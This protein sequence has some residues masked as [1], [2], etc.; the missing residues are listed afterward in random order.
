MNHDVMKAPTR[1]E[2]LCDFLAE[3]SFTAQT[4]YVPLAECLDRVAAEDIPA[5]N[6]IPLMRISAMDGY[7]VKAENFAAG[8]PDVSKWVPGVDF[9]PADTGDDFPDEYDTVIPV[10]QLQYDEDGVLRLQ[11]DFVFKPGACVRPAGC[12]MQPGDLLVRKNTRITPELQANLAAGG[13]AVVPV[14]RKPVIAYIPT[15]S[16]LVPAGIAPQRGQNIETNSLMLSAYLR[17]WGAQVMSYPIVRDDPSALERTMDEALRFADI[18]LLNGGSSKGTEDFNS[19]M[20]ERR[21]SWF[22]HTVRTVPGRPV[23]LSI[24]DGKPVINLP[25]PI[26]AAWVVSSW[27]LYPMICR[28]LG[29]PEEKRRTVTAFLTADLKKGPPV[30]VYTKVRLEKRG[31]F[32]Y[33][34]PLGRGARNSETLR[35][36]IGVLIAPIGQF[37]WQKGEPVT[38]ELLCAEE[39]IPVTEQPPH[40]EL[41]EHCTQC[42]N[43][44]P[45]EALRCGRGK[46]YY[47][48]LKNGEEFRCDNDAV[49]ALV[50]CAQAA[51]HMGRM[52]TLHGGSADDILSALNADEQAQLLA[53]LQKQQVRWNE[54][55]A[56]RHLQKNRG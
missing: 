53:L 43:H 36:G 56:R 28:W 19:R 13:I 38:V 33:A 5:V 7:A 12:M 22:L 55:H 23:G 30:E 6:T 15:G 44:C 4:E 14:V 50:E 17:R 16:E 24:I 52:L 47:A 3:W 1:Q 51:K 25:G 32:Y 41:P 10:E 35:D 49:N 20:M 54:E 42:E 31:E 46:A 27:L 48:R 37:G 9:T 8:T 45:A 39:L 18:V 34:T 11:A 26:M 40:I 29:V 21:A 2:A